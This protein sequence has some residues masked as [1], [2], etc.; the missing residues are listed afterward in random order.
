[1]GVPLW[2]LASA[3]CLCSTLHGFFFFQTIHLKSQI[4]LSG[5]PESEFYN[6]LF[7]T[8]NNNNTPLGAFPTSYYHSVFEKKHRKKKPERK[9]TIN[10]IKVSVSVLVI[11]WQ[12]ATA[13][14]FKTFIDK[15]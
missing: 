10:D 2:K 1:M 15:E 4:N 8:G 12:T 13:R 3:L 5:S 14:K 6:S 7:K 11:M 9:S